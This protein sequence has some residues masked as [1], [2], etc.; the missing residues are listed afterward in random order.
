[1]CNC[2]FTAA[3]KSGSPQLTIVMDLPRTDVGTRDVIRH[4]HGRSSE[5][6]R[7]CTWCDKTR[8]RKEGLL[9]HRDGCQPSLPSLH[10]AM[11]RQPTHPGL[12]MVMQRQPSHPSLHMVMPHQPSL[13]SLHMVMSR[14]PLHPSLHIVMPRQPSLPSLHVVMPRQPSLQSLY[15]VMKR[16]PH[17]PRGAATAVTLHGHVAT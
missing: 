17:M 4:E 11:K 10:M 15:M 7:W 9:A 2:S 1:M 3:Q 14:E 13:P 16:S 6:I 5:N 12:H 8:A